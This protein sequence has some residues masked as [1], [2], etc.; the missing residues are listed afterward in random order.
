MRNAPHGGSDPARRRVLRALAVTIAASLPN[1]RA[2]DKI[3]AIGWLH[4]GKAWNLG[5]FRRALA[6]LGWIEGRNITIEP[7]WANNDQDRLPGLVAELV[8]LPVAVIVTQT[9]LAAIAASRATSSVPIVMAG[10]S[11]PVEVGIVQSL[12]RPGG[13]VTGVT[14][15]PG[16]GFVTKMAQLLKQTA[17]N[18]SRLAV[19]HRGAE[20]DA[21]EIALAAPRLGISVVDARADSHDDVPGALATA[22]RAGADGLF[23]PP[24]AA[25]DPQRQLIVAFALA[26]RWP[27]IG[28]DTDFVAAGGLMS[29]WADWAAIRRQA[30]EYVDKILRGAHPADMPIEQPSKLELVLNLR[31]AAALGL[32]IPQS[33]RLRADELIG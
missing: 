25:N 14:N 7:R 2:T 20:G 31:T 3:Y 32:E 4:L 12:A 33:V 16:T 30:A 1:A 21:R 27:S 24:N 26:H 17:P 23:A 15:N 9:T 18:L 13:N 8:K 22:L 11:N 6:D 5:Q 19:L 28:G 29:Y 10:S